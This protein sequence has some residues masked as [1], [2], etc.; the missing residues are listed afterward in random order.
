MQCNYTTGILMTF[1]SILS[2][3]SILA[4]PFTP[5]TTNYSSPVVAL[6]DGVLKEAS[7]NDRVKFLLAERLPLG[8]VAPT[9]GSDAVLVGGAFGKD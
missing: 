6:E 3:I 2:Y 1:G 9:F 4:P 7:S 5:P 8:G